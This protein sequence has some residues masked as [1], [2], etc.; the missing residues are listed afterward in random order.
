MAARYGSDLIV[1]L[2]KTLG[3]EYVALNPG[4]SFRGIHDSLVNYESGREPNPEIILCCHE[5]IAVA[6]AHGYAKAAGKPMAAIVH[7]VVGLQ[8]ASMAI[9]NA[10]C[11]RTPILVMGGTGPM[12]SSKRRPWIDWIHTALVQGNLVRDFVKWDDQPIGIESIPSSVMRGYRIAMSDPQGPVYLCFDV[13]DQEAP[14]E[15]EIALPNPARYRPPAPLQA[16][17]NAVREAARLLSEAQSPVIVADYVGRNNDAVSS[18]VELA[19]LLSIPVLDLGAR[20]NFPNTHPLNLTGKNRELLARADVILGLDVTD[21]YGALVRHDP[22]THDT[23]AA[24]KSGCK[25]IHVTLSDMAIRGWTSD[26]QELAPVDL[27]IV[28][29]T[30]VFLPALIEEIRRQGRFSKS[31]VDERRKS[32][33]AEH[34]EIRSRWQSELKRRWDER[35]IS[36]PRLA[37]EVWEAIKRESWILVAGAFRGWPS[38]LWQWDKPGLFLGGY[39]GGG[40][41]YGPGASVG[42][43]IP[44]R[45]TETVCV[46]LQ[47]DG[48]LL[49]T[50]SALW[51]AANTGVPLLTVMTNNRTYYN[52]E[53]HQE[54]IAIARGRP[55][56]NK[57][58]GM[59]M[60]KPPV[61]FA[62][63][64][65]SF[66]LFAEGP[67]TDPA[68]IR[69]A[70]D[71]ALRVIK[72]EKRPALVDVYIQPV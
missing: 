60:E 70:I 53:E 58:V 35:P 6:V 25:V 9:Y 14:I 2:L 28:A 32:L 57:V 43:A 31:V 4:S 47:R 48:E 71:R 37:H 54:K 7:D 61:D 45:G 30:R 55:P 62:G 8:H 66:G 50:A 59:R 10:W 36:P 29:N 24:V 21:L 63:L 20:L 26:F 33:A 1:D 67:V 12:N 40:L 64:A 41:G 56:E 68:Q 51:T 69:P 3:I 11:D 15:K 65:R 13:T 52:D 17:A 38:R 34:E 46:N 23:V 16:E 49:Y 27:P 22:A 72:Q 39:G 18:L 19:D 44:Y 42:A 5:E